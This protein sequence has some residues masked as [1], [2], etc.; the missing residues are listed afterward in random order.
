ME[1]RQHNPRPKTLRKTLLSEQEIEKKTPYDRG[2]LMAQL[3][4]DEWELKRLKRER[5]RYTYRRWYEANRETELVNMRKRKARREGDITCCASFA[6]GGQ[7]PPEKGFTLW[8]TRCP[9]CGHVQYCTLGVDPKGRPGTHFR[10]L[11]FD[12][13]DPSTGEGTTHAG[14]RISI[15]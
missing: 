8:L 11:W 3:K 13:I 2:V 9:T 6:L 10:G 4:R 15:T 14:N 5:R 12:H 1:N 7:K